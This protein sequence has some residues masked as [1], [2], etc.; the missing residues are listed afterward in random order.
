MTGSGTKPHGV[1]DMLLHEL[2][3]LVMISP[4]LF[5]FFAIFKRLLSFRA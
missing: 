2:R 3:Q 4:Y 5:G 1:K